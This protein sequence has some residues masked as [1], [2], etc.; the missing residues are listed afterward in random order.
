MSRLYLIRHGETAWNAAKRLQGQADESLSDAG[1]DQVRRATGLVKGIRF[2]RIV[3]SDLKRATETADLLGLEPVTVDRRWREIDVGS[4]RGRNVAELREESPDAWRAWRAGRF[5][6]P[7]GGSRPRWP[8]F[9]RRR[10][11]SRS[12]PMAASYGRRCR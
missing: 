1:C 2:D 10:R 6:P 5:T 7:S 12:S 9:R 11:A 4:W 3:S 8:S